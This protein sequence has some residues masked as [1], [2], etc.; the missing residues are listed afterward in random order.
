V[1]LALVSKTWAAAAARHL[2]LDGA[3]IE[4]ELFS[5]VEDPA[6]ER[7][8]E[9]ERLQGLAQWLQ[10]HGKL[11]NKLHIEVELP[12]GQQD[13]P[14]LQLGAA[15]AVPEVV[16][17]LA[18]A[19]QG[20]RGG[21][22]LQQ[23]RLP[24]LPGTPIS[25]LCGMLPGCHQLRELRL[26]NSYSSATT[27]TTWQNVMELAA[28]LQQMTQLTL[29]RMEEGLLQYA[30][31]LEDHDISDLVEN[32]PGSLQVLQINGKTG[33]DRPYMQLCTSSLRHLVC[34]QAV[35]LPDDTCVTKT[36]V[37]DSSSSRDGTGGR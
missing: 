1:L 18:A 12:Q 35:V 22:R 25:T 17:A 21:L 32:L 36:A 30:G 7:D 23:L 8:E 2:Q 16:A 28:A 13:D 37:S 20:S 27:T 6:E 24:S 14:K 26:C 11:V 10:Q 3:S 33:G 15:A 9:V 34:L 29:L 31:R 5:S 4:I 19:G